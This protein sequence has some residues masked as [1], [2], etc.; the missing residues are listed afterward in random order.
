MICSEQE[1]FERE[2]Q[3]LKS[4]LV[5]RNYKAKNVELMFDKV[6]KMDRK[7][8]LRVKSKESLDKTVFVYP[9][10]PQL[11]SIS[12]I[13][14]KHK[15]YLENDQALKKPFKVALWYPTKEIKI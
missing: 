11:P 12:K 7:D 8:I 15:Y 10:F 3:K 9:Y 2:A 1:S 6:R 13:I 4:M 5:K 14:N